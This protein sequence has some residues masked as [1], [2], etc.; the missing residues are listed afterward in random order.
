MEATMTTSTRTVTVDGIGAVPVTF[1]D[2]GSSSDLGQHQTVL[3]LHGGA[4][5]RSMT[6]FADLL[7][8][9]ARVIVPV[10]PGF[11]GTPRPAQLASV[12]ELAAVYVQLV[13]DLNLS[14]VTVVGNSVGGWIAAELALAESTQSAEGAGGASPVSSVVLV[15]AAGLQIDGAPVPD[16]SGL[17]PDEITQLSYYS[18]EKFRIDPATM[19]DEQ[20]AARA[21]NFGALAA[22]SGS[23]GADPTLLSRLPAITIPTLVVWGTA[24]RMIP[25]EHGRAYAAAIPA[26]QFT[27]IDHAGH[28]PQLEAPAELAAA[29]A[30]FVRQSEH[31]PIK[32]S[33]VGPDG[34]DLALAGPVRLRILEDGSTTSHRLGVAE[35]TIAPHTAGPPQHR[36]AR[37]DEGFYVVSGTAQFTVGDDTY[38]AS[39][40]TLVMVPVGAPHTFANASDEPAVLL[41]T[42]TPDLYVQYF[43]DLR[44]MLTAAG[45]PPTPQAMV[46]VMARYGTEPSTQY[47]SAEG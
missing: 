14:S 25:V 17:T 42:F 46:E 1:S 34:G 10:H 26:A 47:A 35:I 2:T 43:R 5:P 30:E 28:L 45:E 37:H 19:T 29:I 44:A 31:Q 9:R 38:V 24:D 23:A 41:N 32:V 39:A 11:D 33:V 27:L 21:A 6:G 8:A 4:G 13:R 18:P 3:L 16:V 15:D 36:H 7:S 22:Y 40:G 20:R 12:R